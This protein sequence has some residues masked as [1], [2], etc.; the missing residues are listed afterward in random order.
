MTVLLAAG[1]LSAVH[2]LVGKLP[3]LD[4]RSSIWKSVAGGIGISYAFLVLLPK[5]ASAQIVLRAAAD[6]GVYGFLEHHAYLVALAGL[7]LYYGLDIAAEDV[8]RR[9]D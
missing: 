1:V 5:L 2:L 3:F 8:L 9:P 6:G 4:A 7:S